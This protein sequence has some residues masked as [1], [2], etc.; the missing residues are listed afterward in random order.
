MRQRLLHGRAYGQQRGKRFGAGR[1]AAGIALAVV[2]PVVLAARTAREVFS[3]H[4][5]RA[6]FLASLPLLLVFDVA[7][8][9]GE[10]RGHLDAL[11]GR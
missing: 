3:R 9:A 7:W 5:Y 1:N 10:A 8:A 4:R 6:R 11:R 2:V